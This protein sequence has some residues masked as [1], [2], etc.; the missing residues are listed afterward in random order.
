MDT[1]TPKIENHPHL[2]H[3]I[4]R[5]RAEYNYGI[6][7]LSDTA[8]WMEN[9][10]ARHKQ[11]LSKRDYSSA[12][13]DEMAAQDKRV[14]AI[15]DQ[16]EPL[17]DEL[18][19]E[20]GR[21]SREI[22]RGWNRLI[23]QTRF[24]DLSAEEQ[25]ELQAI[26]KKLNKAGEDILAEA[27]KIEASLQHAIQD[28]SNLMNDRNLSIEIM[29]HLKEDDPGAN[30]SEDTLILDDTLAKIHFIAPEDIVDPWPDGYDRDFPA[31]H[32][33]ILHQFRL[34]GSPGM[35]L[36]DYRDILR[37]GLVWVDIKVDYQYFYDLEAGKWIKRYRSK[38]EGYRPVYFGEE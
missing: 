22:R 23:S 2:R 30:P 7:S 28:A 1:N 5:E 32:G 25:D 26:D 37:T 31:P 29:F 9:A 17:V 4:R 19:R 14:L 15:L 12:L 21:E 35:T 8:Y 20:G 38:E 33:G 11:E 18:R 27:V 6:R 13:G 34:Y 3:P 24:E 16:L 10:I 36:V